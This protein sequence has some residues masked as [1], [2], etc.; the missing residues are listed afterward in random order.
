M[1][2]LDEL[3][4]G[5]VKP[6]KQNETEATHVKMLDKSF[7]NIDFQWRLQELRDL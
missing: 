5:T 4:K 6:V 2:T 1:K 7:G 3:E